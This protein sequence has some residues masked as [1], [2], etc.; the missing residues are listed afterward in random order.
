MHKATT[1]TTRSLEDDVFQEPP[2]APTP[3][4]TPNVPVLAGGTRTG[5]SAPAIY[6]GFKAQR[7]E[8][9]NQ[10]EELESTRR[11]IS[12]QLQQLPAN[13]PEQKGL[14]TRM[15]DVDSRIATVDQM[16]ASN[17]AQIATASAV[18]GAVVEP[19]QIIRN[20]PPEEAYV[21]GTI[22]MFVF[23]LPISIAFARRIW[24]RS[25]AV[26]TS[27]PR[28]IADRLSRMEQA[29]EATAV[30]VERIGE[31]QRFLTRLFT[32]GEGA[33]AIGAGAA[34]PLERKQTK[35]VERLP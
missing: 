5:A 16:L 20:G 23:L 22:F 8:L 9:S 25:A 24:R 7:R 26:V 15:T 3:A 10:L 27:F 14:E 33:R 30:E 12:S 17:A 2:Q 28:E 35:S 29:V 4:P 6:E 34:Q 21:V 18:P 31:G 32:E 1:G 19:P 11:D 13:S